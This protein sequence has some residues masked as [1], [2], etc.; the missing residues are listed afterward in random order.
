M[1]IL[2]QLLAAIL[3]AGLAVYFWR[4]RWCGAAL[5]QSQ[6]GLRPAERLTLL[7]ALVAHGVALNRV[8]FAA[9][10]MHFGFSVSLSLMLWLAIA[11]YWVESFHARME[12]LQMLGFPLAAFCVLLPLLLPSPTLHINTDTP[13][14]RLHLIVSMLAYSLFTLAA[15]HALLMAAAERGLRRGRMSP[16]LISL[17]PL[18]T[19]EHLLFRL[20]HLA[21][22]LLTL[23]LISGLFFSEEVFGRAVP[24]DHKTVFALLSWLIFAALLLGRH[25]RGWRGR[26]AL[27]WTLAGFIALLLAYVGSHFVLEVILHRSL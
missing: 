8:L 27:R 10:G 22:V 11:L 3:Y 9:D 20:I 21:F 18:L 2:L 16:L 13:L 12:G 4:T 25:L 6:S 24:F 5:D 1:V 26:L 19:M 15:M 14:F 17:P 23:A 7:V